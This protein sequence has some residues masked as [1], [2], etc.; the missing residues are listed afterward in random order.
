[1]VSLMLPLPL[2]PSVPVQVT[3][4]NAAGKAS[5]TAKLVAV[6]GPLLLTTMV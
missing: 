1:M 3:L 5:L 6:D 2:L 4:V